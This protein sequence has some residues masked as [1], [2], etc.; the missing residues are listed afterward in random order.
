MCETETQLITYF[1]WHKINKRAY[2]QYFR[3]GH[4]CIATSYYVA[5]HFIKTLFKMYELFYGGN[6]F[7]TT[8]FINSGSIYS[9]YLKKIQNFI[10]FMEMI[11]SESIIVKS[12]LSI[13][14]EQKNKLYNNF[15]TII[16]SLRKV[17]EEFT[18]KSSM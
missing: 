9:F 12:Q 14:S 3:F 6:S 15:V 7:A 1:L 17:Y 10:S 5:T 18:F 13:E 16:C 2:L 4:I 8:N 11:C